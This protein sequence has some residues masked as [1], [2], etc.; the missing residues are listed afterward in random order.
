V[1]DVPKLSIVVPNWNHARF[2][3]RNLDTILAQSRQPEEIIVIDDAST[4]ESIA[5]IESYAARYPL[6]RLVRHEANQGVIAVLNRGLAEARGTHVLFAAADDWIL[7]GMIERSMVLLERHPSAGLSSG[8]SLVTDYKGTPPRIMR[9][10]IVRRAPGYIDP[11]EAASLLAE[12]DSWFMGNTVILDR[13]KALAAGGF[14]LELKSLCDMFLYYQLA[15]RHGACFIPAPLA[16]WRRLGSGYSSASLADPQRMLE[17]LT[18]ASRL[19]TGEFATL[20]P[21]AQVRRFEGRWRYWAAAGVIAAAGGERARYLAVLPRS[22][23]LDRAAVDGLL[24]LPALG[25]PLVLLYLFARLRWRDTL[26]VLWRH[27]YWRLL[28]ARQVDR[29]S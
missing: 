5:V 7:P 9:T 20:F 22:L 8:L 25:R 26:V 11:A 17:I 19:M 2:L 10:P 4:D 18:A 3:P 13:T 6:L 15:L 23:A 12:D 27:L 28:R 24:T 29:S 16:V 14:R 21:P 1:P